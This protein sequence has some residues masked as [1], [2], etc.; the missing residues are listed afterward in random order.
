MFVYVYKGTFCTETVFDTRKMGNHF[1]YMQIARTLLPVWGV[2]MVN[3]NNSLVCFT[4]EWNLLG[5]F[6]LYSNSVLVC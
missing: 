1:S 2:E 6:V 5:N 4:S 3:E